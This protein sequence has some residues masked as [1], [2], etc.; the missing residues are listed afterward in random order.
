MTFPDKITLANIDPEDIG[1]AMEVVQASFGIHHDWDAVEN[2]KTFG[3]YCDLVAALL[4]REH[5][6]GCTA[7]QGFYKMRAAMAKVLQCDAAAIRPG[8]TINELFP[9]YGRKKKI[10]ALQRELGI[11]MGLLELKRGV[12]WLVFGCFLVAFLAVFI[13]WRYGL[14]GLGICT[15]LRFVAWSV[16]NRF[17]YATVGEVSGSFALHYYRLARRDPDTVNQH[18]IVPVIKGIF[19]RVLHLDA[20]MLT[21]DTVF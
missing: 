4:A 10:G 17:R 12:G 9:V 15:I 14:L 8:T 11:R 2:A 20:E 19:R 5:R 18:E 6:D 3:A 21:R 16:A 1:G 13:N 7:Q